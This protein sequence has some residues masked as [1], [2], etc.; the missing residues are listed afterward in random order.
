MTKLSKDSAVVD[1][2]PKDLLVS[3]KPKYA[4]AIIDG[5]KTVEFRRKFPEDV[6]PGSRAY[7]YS[8]RPVQAVN[9]LVIIERVERMR[10]APLWDKHGFAACVD[11]ATFDDYFRGQLDGLAV[12]IRSA[13]ILSPG[14]PRSTLKD[15]LRIVPPQSFMYLPLQLEG[16]LLNGST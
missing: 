12:V 9:G 6:A 10:I 14:I 13:H 16:R 4:A 2:F 3:I 5:R 7:I 15:I 8:S 11:R 1:L